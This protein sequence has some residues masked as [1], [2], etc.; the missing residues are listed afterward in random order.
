MSRIEITDLD[1]FRVIIDSNE[2]IHKILG[3]SEDVDSINRC[4]HALN[5]GAP[6]ERHDATINRYWMVRFFD[7]YWA[8]GKTVSDFIDA[9]T[10]QGLDESRLT[11]FQYVKYLEDDVIDKDRYVKTRLFTIRK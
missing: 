11:T 6:L 10:E 1:W 2:K 3:T 7:L 5:E 9:A 4:R 8:T